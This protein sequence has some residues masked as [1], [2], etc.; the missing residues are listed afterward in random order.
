MSLE[1]ELKELAWH[2]EGQYQAALDSAI[3]EHPSNLLRQL[4]AYLAELADHGKLKKTYEGPRSFAKENDVVEL[5]CEG[6]EFSSDSVLDF[7]LHLSPSQMGWRLRDFDFHLAIAKRRGQHVRIHLTA[8]GAYDPLR[9]PRCHIHVDNSEPHI[10]FP[11]IN[12]RLTLHLVCEH[13]EP[14]LGREPE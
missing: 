13:I 3:Q 4:R 8:K 10:P 7:N 12:P 5:I 1:D 14:A 6:V 9:V 2:R 11:I